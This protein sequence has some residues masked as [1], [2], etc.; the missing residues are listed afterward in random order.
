MMRVRNRLLAAGAAL[1][2]F[3]A[4][5]GLG[6]GVGRAADPAWLMSAEA[7]WVNHST[8]IAWWLTW[9]GLA[10]AL[11]PIC[12]ALI[13]VA[14]VRPQWRWRVAFAIVALL[15]AWRG[16]DLFQHLFARPRRLDWVVKHETAFSYPSSHAAIATCFYLLLAA[17]AAR[18]ALPGRAVIACVL[19]LLAIGILWSRLALGAHYLTDIAGGVLWGTVVVAALAACWPTNVFEGRARSSLE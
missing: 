3:G 7:A 19:S 17:F 15:L 6:S 9:F 8:L 1:L 18:S 14:I 11:A 13:V 12:V 4:F 10:Y 5:W 2:F 16:A